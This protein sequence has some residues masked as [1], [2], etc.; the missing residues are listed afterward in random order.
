MKRFGV[1][2]RQVM[3]WVNR[4]V[5]QAVRE[6]F[7]AHRSVW[8]LTIDPEVEA[9]IEKRKTRKRLSRKAKVSHEGDVL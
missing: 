1:S 7:E 5:A 6:D 8:W 3:R 4:G 2:H 9:Q